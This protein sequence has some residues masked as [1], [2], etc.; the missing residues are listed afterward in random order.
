MVEP[1]QPQPTIRFIDEYCQWYESLFSDVRSF[2]AF[3]HLHVGMLSEVKRK[4]LP[5]IAKVCGLDNE[6]S[7]HHCLTDAPW[8]VIELRERR[9]ALILQVLAERPFSVIIDETGDRKKGGH[10]D[11]VKRQYIG[12][13]GKIENGIV[14]VTA[15]GVVDN[16]TFP[17]LFEV[18]KP[19][20]RLKDG[21][22][23][24][25]K[26]EIA[27]GMIRALQAMGFKIEQVLADS[28][29][30]ESGVPFVNVLYEL[31][32]PFVLAI[33]S[34]HGMLLPQGQRVRMNR[35]RQFNR[36]F[37]NG[38][39]ETRWIREIIYGKRRT[40]QFWQ[41]TTDPATLPANGTWYVM[42]HIEK[43]TYKEIG[44]LYGLRNWVEYGL[45]QSKNELGWADFRVTDYGQIEKWWELVMS[46][47]LLVSLH[48]SVLQ[49]AG[50]QK[51]KSSS[52]EVNELFI[53]H[54]Y[55]DQGEGWKSW[56]NNLR[57]ILQPFVF[58][59]LMKPWLEVFSV[60]SLVTGFRCLLEL[61]NCFPGA[62]PSSPR[63]APTL[64]SSR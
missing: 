20:E 9:L 39:S 3:K 23:Y 24:R 14:A 13:L 58:L 36:V 29:Y 2:E 38:K 10:T 47:Y 64:I 49:P 61:M 26:P 16:I 33:R 7:L 56:L 8:C 19:K 4:T 55:W 34:N 48:T 52:S 28:L 32:L 63:D 42:S 27:A 5:A 60:A 31:K 11:Y 57:L 54:R 53:S 21:E 35:W 59:N 51:D 1:R 62:I 50:L 30:G 43:V 44:N 37:S 41:I 40:T 22:S 45:K 12:N 25:T 6:Q 17:L 46:A 18:Y 15:Y